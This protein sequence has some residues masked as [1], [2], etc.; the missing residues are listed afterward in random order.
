[1]ETSSV[2][3]QDNEEKTAKWV[4]QEEIKEEG[5]EPR[6]HKVIKCLGMMLYA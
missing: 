2:S 6:K 5:G 1:M 3:A 4:R